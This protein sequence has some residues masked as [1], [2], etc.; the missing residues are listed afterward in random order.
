[1]QL[2]ELNARNKMEQLVKMQQQQ[3]QQQP[4]N[5]SITNNDV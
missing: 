2:L 1:M 5:N 4:P 3:Q